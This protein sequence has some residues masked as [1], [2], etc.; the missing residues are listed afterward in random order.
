MKFI[1]FLVLFDNHLKHLNPLTWNSA[2]RGLTVDTLLW[3]YTAM[4]NPAVQSSAKVHP[5]S[6][7]TCN[8][9][10]LVRMNFRMSGYCDSCI[11][12]GQ[13]NSFS[14]QGTDPP[15]RL[16][17]QLKYPSPS[18]AELTG[19]DRFSL[20]W[21]MPLGHGYICSPSAVTLPHGGRCSQSGL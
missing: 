6:D 7:H 18:S 1:F 2:L 5:P 21:L 10:L 12:K 20:F 15:Q 11:A 4:T 8:A 16:S 3:P 19:W 14:R 17:S 13:G 9:A